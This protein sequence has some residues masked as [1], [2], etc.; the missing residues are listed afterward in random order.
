[1]L[2]ASVYVHNNSKYNIK[3]EHI[4]VHVYGNISNEFNIEHLIFFHLLQ[5]KLLSP[6]SQLY[7]ILYNI[8]TNL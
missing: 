8:L 5:N 1:M 4:V 3:L 7:I 2:C 6:I